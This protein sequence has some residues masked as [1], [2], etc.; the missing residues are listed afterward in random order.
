VERKKK[1][2]ALLWGRKGISTSNPGGGRRVES[3]LPPLSLQPFLPP[4]LITV[5][6]HCPGRALAAVQD[7]KALINCVVSVFSRGHQLDETARN[8]LQIS[9]AGTDKFVSYRLCAGR[10]MQ[11]AISNTSSH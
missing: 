8:G 5:F 6:L 7:E 10:Q 4:E 2:G 3:S 1:N 11:V 9:S